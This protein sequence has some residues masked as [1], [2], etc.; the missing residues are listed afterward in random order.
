MN[1]SAAILAIRKAQDGDHAQISVY[2]EDISQITWH[3]GNPTNITNQQI[4]DKQAELQTAYD[5]L[6]YA[7]AREIA[8]PNWK[9]FAE[10]YT[11][12]EIGE[13]STK[14]DAYVTKYNLVRNNNPKP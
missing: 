12:K 6:A 4:I 3:D 8:Y 13:D 11:E 10:A 5:A 2:G 1:I 9:E 7:R 14:W